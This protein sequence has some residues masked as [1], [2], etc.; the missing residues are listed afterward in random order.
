M[1]QPSLIAQLF[2]C[3]PELGVSKLDCPVSELS[4]DDIYGGMMT[5][6]G[7]DRERERKGVKR[8]EMKSE[9]SLMSCSV[10]PAQSH[11]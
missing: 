6:R 11:V 8:S 5:C 2:T 7:G 10:L 1:D 9:G 4:A 3:A